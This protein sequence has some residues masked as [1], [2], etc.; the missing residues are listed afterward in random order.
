MLAHAGIIESCAVDKII[1][2]MKHTAL[3]LLWSQ[4]D[5]A[6]SLF[7]SA[8]REFVALVAR[9][10]IS[11]RL[12]AFNINRASRRIPVESKRPLERPG[13]AR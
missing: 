6:S 5:S 8:E 11:S 12:C 7:R 13:S 2:D 10:R 9:R 4:R 1:H 3:L